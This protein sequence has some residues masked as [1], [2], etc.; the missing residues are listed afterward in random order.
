MVGYIPNTCCFLDCWSYKHVGRNLKKRNRRREV[1][2]RV[3]SDWDLAK[4][5]N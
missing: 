3:H 4:S 1:A 5:W 2:V